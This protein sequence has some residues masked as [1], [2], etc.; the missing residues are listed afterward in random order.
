[1]RALE[2]KLSSEFKLV[3]VGFLAVARMVEK[4]TNAAVIARDG[5]IDDMRL[6]YVS[7]T[8]SFRLEELEEENGDADN[9]NAIHDNFSTG[10]DRNLNLSIFLSVTPETSA[11]SILS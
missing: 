2:N 3:Y 5:R 8:D 9:E 11:S 7:E 10:F 1:M 6:V 4:C